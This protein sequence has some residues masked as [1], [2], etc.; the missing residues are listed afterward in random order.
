MRLQMFNPKD[1]IWDKIEGVIC[2]KNID[3]LTCRYVWE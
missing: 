3:V 1:F 2:F